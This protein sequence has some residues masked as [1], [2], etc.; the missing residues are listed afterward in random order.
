PPPL[1]NSPPP[2]TGPAPAYGTIPP[3][4]Q[5]GAPASTGR[6]AAIL[7]GV[8]ALVV[9]IAIGLLLLVRGGNDDLNEASATTT[10]TPTTSPAPTTTPTLPATSA[11]PPAVA[12][13]APAAPGDVFA[14]P[15]GL[16][17]RDLEARGYSYAAAVDYWRHW[18]HTNQMDVDKDGIPCTT[19]YP[20][21][22]VESYWG[23][24]LSQPSDGPIGYPSGLL[25]RDLSARGAST[26]EA[27]LYYV[28]E[29]FPDRMDADGNGIPCE[30]VY[31]DAASVWETG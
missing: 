22:E 2:P 17:C 29:G 11:A 7:G 15:A 12:P 23:V 30:S 28:L 16:L 24:S 10:P 26:R 8:V 13:A 14:Q 3:P 9:L 4:T 6:T 25:C 21:S 20:V 27:L 19:V 5:P 1:L 18:G 31:P